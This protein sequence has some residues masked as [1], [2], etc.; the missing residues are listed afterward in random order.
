MCITLRSCSG[1]ANATFATRSGS[2][3]YHN[4]WLVQPSTAE[5][6]SPPAFQPS[7][8]LRAAIGVTSLGSTCDCSMA[9]L[10]VA[11]ES[12][13]QCVSKQCATT[14]CLASC[15]PMVPDDFLHQ[16]WH[17]HAHR[18]AQRSPQRVSRAHYHRQRLRCA[19]RL[20]ARV[21]GRLVCSVRNRTLQATCLKDPL[22][23]VP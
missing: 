17:L 11:R 10:L 15:E 21:N 19:R 12:A 13:D 3:A 9:P 16:P 1:S 23:T 2:H 4:G 14:G 6:R 5:V 8:A 22:E 7:A 18:L 20:A